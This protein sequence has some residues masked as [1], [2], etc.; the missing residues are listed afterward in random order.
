M[1]DAMSSVPTD[2]SSGLMALTSSLAHEDLCGMLATLSAIPDG[3]LLAN[4]PCHQVGPD[5]WCRPRL[6]Y[7]VDS[8]IVSHKDLTQGDFDS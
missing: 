5:C 2:I 7:V 1:S 8:V 6:T 3:I 4:F